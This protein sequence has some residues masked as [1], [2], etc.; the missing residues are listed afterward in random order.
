MPFVN[1]FTHNFCT[2]CTNR[3][4]KSHGPVC[5]ECGFHARTAPRKSSADKIRHIG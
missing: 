3:Y 4:D 5:P 2:Q 1:Y